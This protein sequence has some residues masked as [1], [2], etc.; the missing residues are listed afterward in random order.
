MEGSRFSIRK[1]RLQNSPYQYLL[2]PQ[3]G[4]V[5]LSLAILH[6][7]LDKILNVTICYNATQ[8]SFWNFLCGDI[9]SITV[10]VEVLPITSDLIGDYQHDRM[11]RAHM[12]RW[13]NR[14]WLEKD[15]LIQQHIMS[16]FDI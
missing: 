11:F 1:H 4:G 15:R 9:T 8:I 2:E 6:Q 12:Q 10:Y 3:T 16:T 14:I 7:H 5:A 13:L